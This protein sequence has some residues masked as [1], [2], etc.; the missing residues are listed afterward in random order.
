M[1]SFDV[2]SV[3]TMPMVKIFSYRNEFPG[4]NTKNEIKSRREVDEEDGSC[5]EKS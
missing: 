1:H 2:D 3:P 4:E 5:A